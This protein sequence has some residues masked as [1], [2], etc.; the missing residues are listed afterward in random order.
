MVNNPGTLFIVSAPSGA[1]KTS[2]VN[3][4]V[5]Q[6]NRVLVSVSHTTREV[7]PGE[8]EGINYHFVDVSTFTQ[9]LNENIFLEHAEVFGNFYGT[10]MTWVEETLAEGK[11]VILEIDWQ[12]AHQIR[13][14]M[15]GAVGI[16]IL[17]PS[18]EALL[19]RLQARKQDDESVIQR[20]MRAA[21]QEISHYVE[22]DYI[23]VNDEFGVALGDLQAI[24]R[25]KRLEREILTP[26]T[27][28]R[29]DGMLKQ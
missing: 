6:D 25:A 28:K 5:K 23:I 29:I 4:L 10:S 26:E 15:P 17:P 16:F 24:I 9:M 19:E 27:T 8:I 1:G 20:R 12:G 11:D 14:K 22:Y 3:A 18:K 13:E 7:R 21:Q 2:L